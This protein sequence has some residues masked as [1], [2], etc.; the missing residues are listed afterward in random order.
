MQELKRLRKARDWSQVRLT[1]KSKIDR[2]T[3]NQIEGGKRS[4]TIETLKKLADALEVEVAD[5]FPK[6]E[7]SLFNN[8]VRRP[9]S[10]KTFKTIRENIRYPNASKLFFA[11]K[12]I[13]DLVEHTVARKSAS[14]EELDYAV[15]LVVDFHAHFNR[16]S[17]R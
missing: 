7:P 16:A 6:L 5:F 3:I 15:T 17:R 2:A 11:T 12:T 4:P 1:K 14:L 10:N 8:D 9:I 13:A